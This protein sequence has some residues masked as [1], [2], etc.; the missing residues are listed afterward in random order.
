MPTLEPFA[1]LAARFRAHHNNSLNVALHMITTPAGVLAALILALQRPEISLEVVR[2][3]V[4]QPVPTIAAAMRAA[5]PRRSRHDLED[6]SRSEPRLQAPKDLAAWRGPATVCNTLDKGTTGVIWGGRYFSL[7]TDQ[8]RPHWAEAFLAFGAVYW[9]QNGALV[10]LMFSVEEMAAGKPMQNSRRRGRRR[11]RAESRRGERRVAC[12]AR[13]SVPSGGGHGAETL[14]P[15][16]PRA[17]VGV[18]LGGAS[19]GQH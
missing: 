10:V 2:G 18:P 12:V 11:R 17:T 16:S 9:G 13:G 3:V 14:S 15:R 6:S 8:V 7:P 19:C 1:D 5:D 4:E